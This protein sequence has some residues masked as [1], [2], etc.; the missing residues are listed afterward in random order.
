[1][2]VKCARDRAFAMRE[3]NVR[4]HLWSAW[5]AEMGDQEVEVVKVKA[6]LGVNA[7]TSHLES[8][9]RAGN[10]EADRLARR[11]ARL[12]G[13]PEEAR[14]FAAACRRRAR[15]L[16]RWLGD[17]HAHLQG[18]EVRDSVG[19]SAGAMDDQDEHDGGQHDAEGGP[20][21]SR[22]P[23]QCHGVGAPEALQLPPGAPGEQATGAGDN[24]PE[25]DHVPAVPWKLR[26]HSIL[27]RPCGDEVA[28]LF[29][30]QCGANAQA[31][32]LAEA[33]RRLRA[34]LHPH[35]RRQ[36]QRLGQPRALTD[37]ERTI[38]RPVLAP[39]AG[40]EEEQE[41][42]VRQGYRLNWRRLHIYD[43]ARLHGFHSP[44][45]AVAWERAAAQY[46]DGPEPRRLCGA[47]AAA[48][49]G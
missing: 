19:L 31:A 38:W 21:T 5:W 40:E 20:A 18:T 16:A 9:R 42:A 37:A 35:P 45:E 34:G 36:R 48:Q 33:R 43:V 13:V 10:A 3:A 27:A 41:L 46:S 11:G 22:R 15:Q 26:G 24:G 7:M 25:V 44:A 14:L 39:G 23:L 17:L 49:V 2:A 29:C 12:W 30:M 28:V 1:G 47:A 4:R 6:H 32:G 8:W